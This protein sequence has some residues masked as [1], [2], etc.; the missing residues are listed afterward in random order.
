MSRRGAKVLLVVGAVGTVAGGVFLKNLYD[1]YRPRDVAPTLALFGVPVLLLAFA[2]GKLTRAIAGVAIVLA[3]AGLAAGA[4]QLGIAHDE[5]RMRG[6]ERESEIQLAAEAACRGTPNAAA[7]DPAPG[8]KRGVMQVT[9]R[10]DSDSPDL[11]FPHTM[12]GLT[13]PRTLAE[14][15]VVVCRVQRG[16]PVGRCDYESKDSSRSLTIWFS[17]TVD[18]L[19]VRDAR[20]LQVLGE[21]TFEGSVPSTACDE[22]IEVTDTSPMSRDVPGMP[23]SFADETAFV[24]TLVEPVEK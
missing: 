9:Q 19:V 17:K 7:S 10:P 1:W 22:K 21:K 15:Q 2:V 16:E 4:I 5:E 6:Y 18:T 24:R 23:P 8:A 12:E 14:L 13:A 3:A 20:T 11:M